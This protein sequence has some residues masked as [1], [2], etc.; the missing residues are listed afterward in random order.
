M[1]YFVHEH[2]AIV[3]RFETILPILVIQNASLLT[4]CCS[5]LNQ[6]VTHRLE[7]VVAVC[8]M[9]TFMANL[10]SYSHN[11]SQGQTFAILG[12]PSLP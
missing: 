3:V 10:P 12:N 7:Q 5:Y 8:I 2:H 1:R 9:S 4:D 6:V 11:L